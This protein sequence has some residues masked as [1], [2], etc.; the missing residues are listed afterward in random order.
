VRVAQFFYIVGG[1]F[2]LAAVAYFAFEYI[3]YASDVVKLALMALLSV[4]L[5]F[6]ARYAEEAADE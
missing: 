1:L 6:F 4:A 5:F 3:V 2:A